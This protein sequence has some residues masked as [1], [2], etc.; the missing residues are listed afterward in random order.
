MDRENK[1]CLVSNSGYGEEVETNKTAT[2]TIK[3]RRTVGKGLTFPNS[4]IKFANFL[5]VSTEITVVLY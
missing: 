4:L 3:E 5:F 2:E 1:E